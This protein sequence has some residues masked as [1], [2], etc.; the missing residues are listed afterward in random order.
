MAEKKKKVFTRAANA[1]LFTLP[2]LLIVLAIVLTALLWGVPALYR[3]S[4]AVE[5]V[6][7]FRLPYRTRDD[8]YLYGRCAEEVTKRCRNIFLGDSAIWGMYA[9]N[10]GT[11]PA[12]LNR[13]AGRECCGNLAIDGLHYVAM[14]TLVRDFGGAIRDRDVY[15]YFNPL[16]V[17]SRKYDLS[18]DGE[19]SVNHPRLLPQFTRLGGYRADFDRRV[20]T[21]LE[22]KL[23]YFSLLHHLRVNFFGN[24][25]F[26]AF[27]VDHPAECPLRRVSRRLRPEET[28]HRGTRDNWK[29][30]GIPVQHWE[31][32]ALSESRQWRALIDTI[33]LLERRGNR[34]T[35]LVGNINPELLDAPTLAG[36]R[37][38]RQSAADALKRENIDSIVLPE[39]PGE[40]YADASHPLESG[41][42][43]LAAF[44]LPHLS[45]AGNER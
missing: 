15:I 13:L 19:F 18:E 5:A 2:E 36:L 6:R 40:L 29:T 8:Y 35:V 27:L 9:S 34:V 20:G 28:E 17:N 3:H 4:T 44:L 7:D 32:V 26:K 22:Q 45:K 1:L 31:W 43:K 25:D 39:L 30:R 38:L 12:Q 23:A 41:Y 21:F 10:S 11:L 14:E 33:R 37:S 42:A 16:W 24:R